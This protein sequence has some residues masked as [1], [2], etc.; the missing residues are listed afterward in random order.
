MEH[1]VSRISAENVF[2]DYS[3]FLSHLA[4]RGLFRIRPGLDRIQAT[5]H[6]LGLAQPP[7]VS[8]QVVGTNGKG[9]TSTLL[10]SL[11]RAHGLRVG[12]YTSPHFVSPRERIRINGSLLAE[13]EWVALANRVMQ[14][15]GEELSY[16][17]LVT[18]I[19]ALAFAEQ[20]VEFAVM[21]TGLGGSWDA[22]TALH[23]D[24]VLFTPIDLDHQAVLGPTLADIAEDKAGAMRP[25]CPA[26]SLPQA[27]AA[28]AE[29]SNVAQRTGAQLTILPAALPLPEAILSG[30]RPL[31]LLGSHQ[32]ANARL[33]LA[34]WQHLTAIPKH[35]LTATSPLRHLPPAL[36]QYEEDGLCSAWIP[37]RMQ[38]IA[39]AGPQASASLCSLG[40]PPLLLDGAHNAHG[41]AALGLSLARLGIAPA[42]V[43]FSC[44]IDK[45]PA[46]TIPHLR[47]M[48][49]GPIFV[50]PIVDNPR[51]MPPDELAHLIGI[52]AQP[53]HSLREALTLAAEH[54]A[55]RLPEAFSG[56]TPQSPLLVCGSL[57]LLG[58]FFELFPEF[59]ESP[60]AYL[61]K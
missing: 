1:S 51:A 17:E 55:D 19:A 24:L 45:D 27:P 36:P 59:L 14:A 48:S 15:A 42:A 39:P 60:S 47:A 56:S 12:L 10:A 40:R 41:L 2:A 8:V 43:V 6:R 22:T 18:A 9:S 21:E 16:F 31:T 28:Q 30:K 58:E 34:G 61:Q 49:T 52:N 46:L 23:T 11:A 38:R 32:F 26:L 33:A 29:L 37:G 4:E 5:I 57:Y 13:S 3:A 50:P 20:G 53:V 44:L 25:G 54:M 35:T 7:Y